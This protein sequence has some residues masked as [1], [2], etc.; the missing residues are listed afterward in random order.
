LSVVFVASLCQIKNKMLILDG[1][2]DGG[3]IFKTCGTAGSLPHDSAV[4]DPAF[5]SPDRQR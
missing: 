1:F 2:S 5:F 4:D 3:K